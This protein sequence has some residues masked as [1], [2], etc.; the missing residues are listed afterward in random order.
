MGL[1]FIYH[2][3]CFGSLTI[4]LNNHIVRRTCCT[5]LDKLQ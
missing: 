1:I 3:A 4:S 2:V 5:Y